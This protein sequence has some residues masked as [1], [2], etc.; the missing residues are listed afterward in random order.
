MYRTGDLGRWRR[1]GT[2]EFL[3]R[4][5][6]QVKVRGFRVELAEIE[7]ALQAY[8]PV[9]AA[10][11]VVRTPGAAETAQLVAYAAPRAGEALVRADLERY[12]GERLPVY[13]LPS[14]YVVLDA[15]PMT[16]RGKVDRAALPDTTPG[17]D[18][19]AEYEASKEHHWLS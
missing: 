7:T 14:H 16:D 2:L 15:L 9:A 5:D 12:L 17:A 4:A 6:T 13:M 8:P 18:R 10:A 11:V 1:D 3:G 19:G